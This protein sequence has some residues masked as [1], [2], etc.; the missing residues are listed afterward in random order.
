VEG[1]HESVVQGLLSFTVGAAPATHAPEPLHVSAPLHAF[2]SLQESPAARF[3]CTTPTVEM[4][5]SLVHG[6]P[7]STVGGVPGRHAPSPLQV[8]A[9]LHAF[10]SLHEV[11]ADKGACITPRMGLH[12]SLV[13]GLLSSTVGA[14][15]ATQAPEPLHFSRPLHAFPS[16]HEDPAAIGV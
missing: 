10:P 6:L 14:T 5:V 11:P 2:P 15:P 8:S 3:T 1:L 4:Q 12:E 9:P 7:S 16:L 13:Q